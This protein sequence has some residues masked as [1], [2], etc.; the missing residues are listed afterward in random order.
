M[1]GKDRIMP[2]A[3]QVHMFQKLFLKANAD[4]NDPT[5]E[6]D[7]IDW[8]AVV[9]ETLHYQENLCELQRNYP[10]HSWTLES[11]EEM[12]EEHEDE[13][14]WHKE[15]EFETCPNC[16]HTITR[17]HRDVW[18]RVTEIKQHKSGGGKHVY[19]RIQLTTPK[20]W[21]GRTAWIYV[22]VPKGTE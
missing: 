13:H 15:P 7:N 5:A 1:P 8:Q 10:E 21:I 16:G 6:M 9:D 18:H 17:N 11:Y 19:G 3:L 4:R 14:K 12:T 22:G 20:E 2:K